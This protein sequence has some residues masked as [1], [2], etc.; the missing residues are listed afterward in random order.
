MNLLLASSRVS[1]FCICVLKLFH[2]SRLF[3]S[4]GSWVT[5]C[6]PGPGEGFLSR[7]NI[8]G[9]S[10]GRRPQTDPRDEM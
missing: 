4:H 8:E 9:T 10:V 2:E 3:P 5:F 7:I 6:D 1:R